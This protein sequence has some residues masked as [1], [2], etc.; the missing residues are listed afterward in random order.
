MDGMTFAKPSEAPRPGDALER[1]PA[2]VCGTC[3]MEKAV[4]GAC[5]CEED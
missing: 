1:K 3:F 2:E 4:N 5:G